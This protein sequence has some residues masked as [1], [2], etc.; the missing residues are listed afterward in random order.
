MT[1]SRRISRSHKRVV[2]KGRGTLHLVISFLYHSDGARLLRTSVHLG[3]TLRFHLKQI[4]PL[5]GFTI[6]VAQPAE[7]KLNNW[8]GKVKNVF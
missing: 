8:P 1:L 7:R 5:A 2:K 4:D 3:L 6:V